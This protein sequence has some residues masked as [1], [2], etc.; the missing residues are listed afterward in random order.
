MLSSG[1]M[2]WRRSTARTLSSIRTSARQ[3]R[4]AREVV[5][6]RRGFGTLRCGYVVFLLCVVTAVTSSAQTF[7]TLAS[8][9][10]TNG[11]EPI[12][13]SL[14]QGLDGNL[15]GTTSG[16][17][18][19]G[20]STT[21]GTVFKVTPSGTLTTLH[22]FCALTNCAD[23]EHPY[24]G[25]VLSTDGNFYG[26]TTSGGSHG[27]G[28]VFKLT[29]GGTLTTLYSFCAKTNCVDGSGPYAPLVQ[30]T[31]GN[32][33]GTTIRGGK[34][35]T[36]C[37]SPNGCG[38]VFKITPSGTLTT[39]YFFCSQ[40]NCSDGAFPYGAGLI[41][42]ADGN[43]YGT[44]SSG[45]SSENLGTV[46]KIT[47]TGTLTTL[48]QFNSARYP[49]AGLVQATNGNFY[50]TSYQGGTG[51]CGTNFGCGT[52][53]RVTPKVTSVLYNFCSQSN[54][55]DGSN[56]QAP[57]IQGT[58]GNLYGTTSSGGAKSDGSLFK[59][60]TGGTLTTLHSFDLS[61][62]MAPSDGLVQDTDGNFYGITSAGGTSTTNC[63]RVGCGTVFKLSMGLGPFVT[64][65]PTSAKVGTVIKILGTNL[66]GATSVSFNGTA[67]TFTVVSKTQIKTTVPSGATTGTVTVD[68]PSGI[69]KSNVVFRVRP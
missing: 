34:N 66:T 62:G 55:A 19:T 14:V 51:S 69:L 60:T 35:A 53:F 48:H 24:A 20:A 4:S 59:I 33:Y 56:P 67:A 44:A 13:V 41:Q 63:Y 38:T 52:V 16:E 12:F 64:T 3:G 21:P 27:S 43:L 54:C 18:T 28:T 68:T 39:L 8:F 61:D 11:Q 50:G 15:Y 5:K 26:T 25:L 57:L 2:Q 58:D 23:G 46:F 65:L 1:L 47:T 36:R 7:T 6:K 37:H 29:S 45:G 17:G 9:D 49:Y 30:A 10:I 31:D 42:G 32:F 22:S 40:T